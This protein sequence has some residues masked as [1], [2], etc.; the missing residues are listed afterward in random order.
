MKFAVLLLVLFVSL[1]CSQLLC[2]ED[3][4]SPPEWPKALSA[5]IRWRANHR[6]YE[7]FLRMF[8]DEANDR[9]RTDAMVH[10]D[11]KHLRLEIL[12]NH[13]EKNIF[14]VVREHE[15]LECK[16]YPLDKKVHH[17]DL[18]DATF[19]G[20]VLIEYDRCNHWRLDTE[21]A[22]YDIY[23][24][25]T[26]RDFKRI[27]YHYHKSGKIGSLTYHEFDIGMQG[28]SLF[29]LPEMLKDECIKGE[30]Y[31]QVMTDL[32]E[33]ADLLLIN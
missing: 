2:G 14:M 28:N 19:M 17:H 31:N 12:Y 18:K 27:D 29:K 11:G 4:P 23:E 15:K 33:V 16:Y 1:A 24:D 10:I 25:V 22:T 7:G 13:K 3:K 8:W 20:T 32:G 21:H 26:D 6:P 9:V 30:D 5:S